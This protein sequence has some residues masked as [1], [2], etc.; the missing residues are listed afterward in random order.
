M[1][2]KQKI[3]YIDGSIPYQIVSD[4]LSKNG[5]RW[6]IAW[7]MTFIIMIL[8]LMISVTYIVH[9]LNSTATID[10]DAV[11]IQDVETIDDSTIKI[12]DDLWEKLPLQEQEEE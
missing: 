5:T 3:D 11:D 7:L 9:L 4:T 1:G 6:F 8:S 10:S 12:G 2:K